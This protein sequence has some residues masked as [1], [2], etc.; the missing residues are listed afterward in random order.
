MDSKEVISYLSNLINANNY[1]NNQ[2]AP[3]KERNQIYH[4][5]LLESNLN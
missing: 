4:E 5:V 2:N 1:L 3:P